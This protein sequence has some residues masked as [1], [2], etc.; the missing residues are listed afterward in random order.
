MA[1]EASDFAIMLTSSA[2]FVTAV[3]GVGIPW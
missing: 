3:A 2:T 1:W